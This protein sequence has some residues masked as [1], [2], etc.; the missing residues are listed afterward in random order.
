M[1]KGVKI[2]PKIL[3]IFLIVVYAVSFIGSLFVSNKIN[4][5]WYNSIKPK[6]T[7]PNYVFPVVWNII[8]FLIAISAYFCWTNS[9]GKVRKNFLIIYGLNL[10]LNLLWGFLYFQIQSPFLAFIEIIL[11]WFSILLM[12][13]YSFRIDKKAALLIIPYF[14]WVSFA[15]V[16]NYLSFNR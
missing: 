16:L 12:F 9:K 5:D 11:L 15:M 8:F 6:I 10:F 1:K 2:N 7:P 13:Y 14:F 3:I 4:S